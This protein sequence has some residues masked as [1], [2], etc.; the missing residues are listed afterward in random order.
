M[1][2]AADDAER[3]GRVAELF[4]AVPNPPRSVPALRLLAALHHLVLSGRAPELA[5]FYPSAGGGRSPDGAWPVALATLGEHA[6]WVRDRLGR[7]VQTNEPGRA[8]VLF[9]ALLWLTERFP[10]PVR[11][12]EIGASAG[13]NLLAD[14]FCYVS[15]GQAL[16]AVGS[17][18]RFVEPWSPA[19]PIDLRAAAGRLHIAEREGCDPAPL[20]P[21][22]PEDRITALSYIWPDELERL[23]R[24]RLALDLA[25]EDPPR[26]AAMPA[27]SWLPR[28]LAD[29]REGR[30]AVVW[31]SI[32]R[33]YIEPGPWEAIE[34]A[35]EDAAAGGPLV[36][37][38]MEPGEDHLTGM[39]LTVIE[40]P[41]EP[42]RRLAT[43]GD[44]GPP[45]SWV[46][47]R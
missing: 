28:A 45:V 46:R 17:P 12:L 23:E 14:R 43:C 31:Q 32:V 29:G 16:G 6:D 20:D 15:G 11:L 25:A 5:R 13:L 22:E 35:F 36:W 26:V 8:T 33:Q 47:A 30:L 3:G 21:R 10:L 7:T 34:R 4:A 18:V 27:E 39:E 37:L 9:A 42:P 44:H 38:R 41:G 1:R 24:A 2:R 19:P 40:T